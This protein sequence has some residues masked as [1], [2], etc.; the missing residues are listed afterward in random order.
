MA[1]TEPTVRFDADAKRFEIRPEGSEAVAFLDV[2]PGAQVWSLTHTEVPPAFEGR[3]FGTAL[4][5]AAL[6]HV[7]GVGATVMPLCPFVVAYL[8]RH[9]EEADV[10]H[11]RFRY[12]LRTA[13]TPRG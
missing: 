13:G 10:V 8:D 5:R 11:E 7:R 12:M 6:D 3:G 9:P 4:V 2:L 1:H